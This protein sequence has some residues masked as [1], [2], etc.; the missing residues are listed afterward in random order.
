MSR[1]IPSRRSLR[2]FA[3]ALFVG[4]LALSGC[5]TEKPVPE[6]KP[7]TD[8]TILTEYGLDGLDVRE[9]IDTLDSTPVAERPTDLLASVRPDALELSSSLGEVA[10][11]MPDDEVYVSVAPYRTQTHDCHF[12]SLTTCLGELSNTEVDVT[13]TDSTTGETVIDETRTSFDNGFVGLWLPRGIEA[14]L[15]LE[16]GGLNADVPLSTTS[17]ADATCVTTAELS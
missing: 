12:H 9:I 16:S 3:S 5:A 4:A 7:A 14:E 13:V 11:P 6:M 10:L 1:S 8:S 17:D 2:L 15:H